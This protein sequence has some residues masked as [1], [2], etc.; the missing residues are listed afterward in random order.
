MS[1]DNN[2]AGNRVSLAD[3]KA[4]EYLK[5]EK[6]EDLNVVDNLS[7]HLTKSTSLEV[8][9]SKGINNN[10]PSVHLRVSF[11]NS[12][13]AKKASNAINAKVPKETRELKKTIANAEINKDDNTQLIIEDSII[14]DKDKV[15]IKPFKTQALEDAARAKLPPKET[16]QRITRLKDP[17]KVS[18]QES[19]VQRINL[20]KKNTVLASSLN[21]SNQESENKIRNQSGLG[22]EMFTGVIE[23]KYDNATAILGRGKNSPSSQ[24]A[25]RPDRDDSLIK[26]NI[27]ELNGRN[28][29]EGLPKNA[30][31]TI[32]NAVIED[33]NSLTN[34][35]NPEGKYKTLNEAVSVAQ[36]V[37][38]NGQWDKTSGLPTLKNEKLNNFVADQQLKGHDKFVTLVFND[39][40]EMGNARDTF[41]K[42]KGVINSLDYTQSTK[43]ERMNGSNNNVYVMVL[44]VTPE[45]ENDL[46]NHQESRLEALN[47]KLNH[48]LTPDQHKEI[49]KSLILQVMDGANFLIDKL[50]DDKNSLHT[51]VKD[52]IGDDKKLNKVINEGLVEHAKEQSFDKG[53]RDIQNFEREVQPQYQKALDKHVDSASLKKADFETIKKPVE[54]HEKTLK[55]IEDKIRPTIE[56]AFDNYSG[57]KD[58]D[59]LQN[60]ITNIVKN[61]A[62]QIF[63][64]RNQVDNLVGE[65]QTDL[66]EKVDD[67]N[68]NKMLEDTLKSVSNKRNLLQAFKGSHT[69]K[70]IGQSLQSKLNQ[71]I[72]VTNAN[73]KKGVTREGPKR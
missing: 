23:D 56:K 24:N 60:K 67:K 68:I 16:D 57:A 22:D 28:S 14:I 7:Q 15:V 65:G 32:Q 59:D 17:I 63:D 41:S 51:K 21:T 26:K 4:V 37:K 31:Q 61:S 12:T 42:T 73:I 13:E 3:P 62:R 71:S 50:L 27:G 40:Y 53:I 11:E 20:A 33:R 47:N 69:T 34:T 64:A 54:D 38:I 29:P 9:Y 48:S 25:S 39:P 6:I 36:L 58:K 46:K 5:A 43:F 8:G 19:S 70:N 55:A 44:N 52:A 30:K 72:N 66:K 49:K 10:S 18:L 1:K 45:L 2:N 35:V